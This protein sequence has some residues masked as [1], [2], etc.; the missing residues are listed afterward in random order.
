MTDEEK[1]KLVAEVMQGFDFEKT[2]KMM[3]SEE[4]VGNKE[5][6]KGAVNPRGDLVRD[7]Y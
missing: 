3:M 2:R 1:V 4:M 6:N 5:M 7:M